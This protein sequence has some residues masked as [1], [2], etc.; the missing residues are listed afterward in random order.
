[1]YCPSYAT[2][3]ARIQAK[4]LATIKRDARVIR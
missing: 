4:I 3:I 1:M 2:E